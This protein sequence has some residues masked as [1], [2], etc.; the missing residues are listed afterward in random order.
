[1]QQT[2]NIAGCSVTSHINTA[3][4]FFQKICSG[5][6]RPV[7]PIDNSRT[8]PTTEHDMLGDWP[9]SSPNRQSGDCNDHRAWYARGLADQFTQSTIWGLYRP[10][11]MICSGTGRLV[12][13]FWLVWPLENPGAVPIVEQDVLGDRLAVSIQSQASITRPW[14]GKCNCIMFNWI[15]LTI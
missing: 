6:G 14:L 9:T 13:P 2:D 12:H 5:T 1:M 7:R 3:I 10:P 8:V 15:V 4:R 11:S